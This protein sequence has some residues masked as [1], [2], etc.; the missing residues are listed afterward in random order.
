MPHSS[1]CLSRLPCTPTHA[2]CSVS[3]PHQQQ[4]QQPGSWRH[5]C[6]VALLLHAVKDQGGHLLLGNLQHI[7]SYE[8][9]AV[10]QQELDESTLT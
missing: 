5:A 4:H 6:K 10:G 1:P 8:Q 7:M 2:G 3:H 9:D